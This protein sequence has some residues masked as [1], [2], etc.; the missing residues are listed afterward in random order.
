MSL[1][2]PLNWHYSE[3][4][5]V[6]FSAPALVC[7]VA[8]QQVPS[9]FWREIQSTDWRSKRVKS[10]MRNI[11][12]VGTEQVPFDFL[13]RGS[14][15]AIQIQLSLLFGTYWEVFDHFWCQLNHQLL[16]LFSLMWQGRGRGRSVS[17]HGARD[18]EM[19][20]HLLTVIS[21]LY[22]K[23][24]SLPSYPPSPSLYFQLLSPCAAQ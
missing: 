12:P 5:A 13:C 2:V 8:P 4:G 23:P 7:F 14:S 6:L 11:S 22:S 15:L 16:D 9:L 3:P 18:L 1:E 20:P 24:E 10:E 17:P 19:F 21:F